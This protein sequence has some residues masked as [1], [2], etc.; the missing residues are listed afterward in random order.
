MQLGR[1]QI[2]DQSAGPG[3]PVKVWDGFIRIFHWTLV[4][5]FATA[6]ISG[7]TGAE[8][9]HTWAGYAL[10][11]LLCARVYWGLAGSRYARFRAF[12]FSAQETLAYVRSLRSEHPRHYYGHNP[13]G[14]LMVFALLALLS[15]LLLSGLVTL[16]AIDFDGPLLFLANWLSDDA[17]YTVQ[18]WHEW[19]PY[20][21]LGLVVLHLAGVVLGSLQ[22]RENLVRA[23]ITGYKQVPPT[24]S[25]QNKEHQ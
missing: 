14:A 13:A 9:L 21:G 8:G 15:L 6:F 25:T 11:G 23:M 17:S 16:A 18:A 4:L 7:E 24:Q 22:H 2:D 5:G 19:L 20:L 3:S 1:Q 10:G 12:L